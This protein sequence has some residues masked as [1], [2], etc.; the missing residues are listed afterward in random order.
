M[1]ECAN[2][3]AAEVTLL[4]AE[5]ANVHHSNDQV[6]RENASLRGRVARLRHLA[7]LRQTRRESRLKELR[8]RVF[9]KEVSPNDHL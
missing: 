4:A 2:T 7:S 6:E 3:K 5:L 8:D 9:S 1:T